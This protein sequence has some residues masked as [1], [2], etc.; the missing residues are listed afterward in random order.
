MRWLF[1]VYASIIFCGLFFLC[2]PAAK[3]TRSPSWFSEL[4]YSVGFFVH[5]VNK[6]DQNQID[7]K[8]MFHS[9]DG[10]AVVCN[11]HIFLGRDHVP[12]SIKKNV[13]RKQCEVGLENS[14]SLEVLN[15]I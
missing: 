14:V 3:I 1:R 15:S 9:A 10:L 7:P 5:R 11:S 2:S 13:S 12:E 8:P 4:V 6:K